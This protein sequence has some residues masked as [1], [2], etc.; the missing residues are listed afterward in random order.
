MSLTASARISAC[1][2]FDEAVLQIGKQVSEIL[3]NVPE[4]IKQNAY[5]IRLRTGHAVMIITSDGRYTPEKNMI[6][7]RML[8]NEIF[9]SVCGNAVYSHQN[10]IA[11]GSITLTGGHRAGIC[12]R[13]VRDG[14]KT[15]SIT[16][17]S[18]VCI[19]IAHEIPGCANR[20]AEEFLQRDGGLLIAGPPC[21]GKTTILRDLAR[22][23]S[24]NKNVAIVDEKNEIAAVYR[25]VPQLDIGC[26]CDVLT[27]QHK[28]IGMLHAIRCMSPDILICDEIGDSEEAKAIHT[29]LYTGVTVIAA[30][31]CGTKDELVK[32]EQFRHLRDCGAFSTVAVLGRD[33]PGKIE[34]M[35]DICEL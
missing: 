12:G 8:M 28:S 1:V 32:R 17:I 23:L 27:G 18:S 33:T 30:M 3:L 21:S 6:I 10:E 11:E 16:D 14:S 13:A 20:L 19:R 35:A 2:K 15:V 31:H 25:G 34:F 5:E 24:S 4:F 22:N 7:S 9:S 29:A 26:G